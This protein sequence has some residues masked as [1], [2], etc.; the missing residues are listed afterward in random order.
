L[1]IQ[2][3]GFVLLAAARAQEPEIALIADFL[4]AHRSGS[5]SPIRGVRQEHTHTLVVH[6]FF[7]FVDRFGALKFSVLVHGVVVSKL[8]AICRAKM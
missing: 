2:S 5:F 6:Q 3:D 4:S 7:E 8:S 1:G